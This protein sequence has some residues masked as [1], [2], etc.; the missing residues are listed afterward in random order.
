MTAG[1]V[2]ITNGQAVV[3]IVPSSL[4]VWQ[5]RG[6]VLADAPIDAVIAPNESAIPAAEP[7]AAE[8]EEPADAEPDVRDDNAETL[9]PEGPVTATSEE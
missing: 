8:P 5:Q 9:V 1:M 2:Q 7:A 6:W 3:E 4:E